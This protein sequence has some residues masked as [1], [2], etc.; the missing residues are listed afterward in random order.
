VTYA[1]N[2]MFLPLCITIRV[3]AGSATASLTVSVMNINSYY[4]KIVEIIV[5]YFIIAVWW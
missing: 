3:L 4:R 5:Y 1:P 2:Q